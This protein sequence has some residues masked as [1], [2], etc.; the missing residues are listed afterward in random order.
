MNKIEISSSYLQENRHDKV[1]PKF[2]V[3]TPAVVGEAM[4][5]HGLQLA[6]LSTGKGRHEDKKDF[7][8]TLSRYRG[9]QISD[10][11]HLDI[12]YDSK[13]MGRGCDRILLGV[14]RMICTNGLF[15]GMNFFKFDVRHNGN[16]YDSLHLGI[17][18]A[19]K[20]KHQLSQVI[21]NMQGIELNPIQQGAMALEACRLLVPEHGVD[22]HHRLLVANRVEDRKNDLWTTYNVIQENAMQGRLT[23]R[24][25]K[26]ENEVT[27]LRQMSARKIKP[28]SGKDAGFNQGL[29]DIAEKMA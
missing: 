12:I 23:Y 6:S 16:T 20:M 3:V 29:F 7:Q 25:P 22:V 2:K 5:N 9:P 27:T 8:R 11:V 26:I 18:A 15:V 21:A 10:G 14:Y 13:H 24:L 1:S 17:D 19:L 4:V 28:N